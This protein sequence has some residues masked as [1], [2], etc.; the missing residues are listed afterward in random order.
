MTQKKKITSI[1]IH[2]EKIGQMKM[3]ST[4]AV[5]RYNIANSVQV[6]PYVV[7]VKPGNAMNVPHYVRHAQDQSA[8]VVLISVRDATLQCVNR[9]L[10]DVPCATAN[11]ATNVLVTVVIVETKH[12]KDVP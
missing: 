5:V 4:V 9:A 10:K 7:N 3:L 12:V 11:V 8:I 6:A 1:A 2:A